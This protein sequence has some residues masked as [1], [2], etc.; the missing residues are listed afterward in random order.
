LLTL[1]HLLVHSDWQARATSRGYCA[2]TACVVVEHV[3]DPGLEIV[4]W[5]GWFNWPT[6][7]QPLRQALT[8]AE[9]RRVVKFAREVARMRLMLAALPQTK[10]APAPTKR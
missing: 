1:D 5:S 10:V 2:V 3:R 8:R 4:L 9:R 7:S 6:M